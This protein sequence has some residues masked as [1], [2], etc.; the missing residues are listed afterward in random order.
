M[1]L[2]LRRA[3]R[4]LGRQ[5]VW[6]TVALVLD[7]V[8][9]VTGILIGPRFNLAGALAVG[10]L[11]ACA[12]CNGRLTALAAGFALALCAL[13]AAV[14]G[15]VSAADQGY[16]F[17]A[18]IVAGGLA[19]LTAVIR[20]RREGALIKISERVQHAI[21]RPLPAEIAATSRARG[22]RRSAAARPCWPS[23]VSW[24]SANRA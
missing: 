5:P 14:T 9:A 16:H 12:R 3:A 19:V 8:I 7:V 6:I 20:T 11:L 21:L 17:G 10:P 1:R 24:P 2:L 18:V 23:S 22:W 15:T 13:V 4:G